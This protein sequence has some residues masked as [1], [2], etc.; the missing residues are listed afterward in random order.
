MERPLILIT[1]D[2]GI[3]ARGINAIAD[4]AARH[5]DVVIVAP[6]GPRSAQSSA[7]TIEY[8]VSAR[9][10][11]S[12]D[13]ITRYAI[14]GTPADCVKLAMSQLL[15]R[16]PAL[17]ISGINHGS[18]ASANVIYSGTIG[19]AIEGCRH[20][21]PSIG[22]SLCDHS[23]EADFSHALPFFERIILSTLHAAQPMP[24]NVCLNVNAPIGDI[25]GIRV[26]H[27]GEGIWAD[28]FMKDPAP[29]SVD[30]YWMVGNFSYNGDPD[31]Q[32]A[33][34]IALDQG[35]IS[36]VPVHVDM[37]AYHALEYCRIYE[38]QVG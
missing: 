16:R 5:A 18:N 31:D 20:D 30:Y 28:E 22:F 7:L 37:T 17:L 29:R 2:D 3:R 15:H 25:R 12:D 24:H 26:C 10:L 38:T 6:D 19:A 34:Q 32:T 13:G 14:S 35:Y 23:P 11:P 27:Q 9:R 8:P 21:I 33:D 1:N 4:I 36:I